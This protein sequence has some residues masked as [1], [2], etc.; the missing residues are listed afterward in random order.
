MQTS[1]GGEAFNYLVIQSPQRTHLLE[2]LLNFPGEM[3]EKM[4]DNFFD[5]YSQEFLLCFKTVA[6]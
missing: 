2:S 4:S 6:E 1:D 5:Y 3:E